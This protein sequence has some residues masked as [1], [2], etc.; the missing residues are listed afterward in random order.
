MPL[1]ERDYSALQRSWIVALSTFFQIDLHL[2]RRGWQCPT[3]L[4]VVLYIALIRNAGV[5]AGG[6]LDVSE[7]W[8]CLHTSAPINGL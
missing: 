4:G 8:L 7:L 1:A 3:P 5:I 2:L 6:G